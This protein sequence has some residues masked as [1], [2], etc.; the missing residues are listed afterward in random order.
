VLG[1][2]SFQTG[3]IL[4]G[5]VVVDD[6]PCAALRITWGVTRWGYLWTCPCRKSASSPCRSHSRRQKPSN[7]LVR[8][9]RWVPCKPRRTQYG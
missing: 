1:S 5:G 8:G 7:R 4:G 6:H 2:P 9:A 3:S